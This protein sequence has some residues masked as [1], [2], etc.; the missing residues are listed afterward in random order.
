MLTSGLQSVMAASG[1]LMRAAADPVGTWDKALDRFLE[2]REYRRP[3][4]PYA[5]TEEW[6]NKLHE[7]LGLPTGCAETRELEPLWLQA[8]AELRGRGVDVGPASFYG[9][10]DGD[11]AL[12]RAIWCLVRHLRP[13]TVV[14]TGVGHGFTSRFVLEAL[15]RNGQGA[16]TSIDRPPLDPMMRDRVGSAVPSEL[17]SGWT[18]IPGTSRRILP[19]TLSTLGGIDIFIH[20]SL[21]T[22]RN[23]RFEVDRA[24]HALRPGGALVIDDVDTNWGL[25]SFLEKFKPDF[26]VVCQAE[27]VRPDTRRFN[28]RGLFAIILKSKAAASHSLESKH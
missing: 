4:Y 20:D 8:V 9:Y 25:R 10:N 21:H 2:S 28:D 15:S 5:V 18:L 11:A 27:P 16:L 26:A 24:W 3:L 22:E 17:R 23:V 14:E 7:A 19:P 13:Q 12:I 6:E 1:R